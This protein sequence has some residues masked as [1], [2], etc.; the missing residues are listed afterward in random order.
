MESCFNRISASMPAGMK[1]SCLLVFLFATTATA[2]LGQ[3]A[4]AAV[5]L[6]VAMVQNTSDYSVNTQIQQSRLVR[7]FNTAKKDKK[8]KLATV[9]AVAIAARTPDEAGSEARDQGCA[10]VLYTTVASLRA[11]SDAQRPQVNRPGTIAIG[12]DP[13][14]AYPGTPESHDPVFEA[15]VDFRIDKV[16]QPEPVLTSSAQAIEHTGEDGAVAATLDTV[17]NRTRGALAKH[18]VHF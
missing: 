8:G 13:I 2:A 9:E 6:C 4:P 7:D 17:V 3:S 10:Y 18:E 14:G 1:Q 12:R 15:E 11:P 16:D 5:K